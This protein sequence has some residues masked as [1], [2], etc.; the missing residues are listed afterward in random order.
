MTPLTGDE[1]LCP[2]RFPLTTLPGISLDQQILL[3]AVWHDDLCGMLAQGVVFS[4]EVRAVW[5]ELEQK[6]RCGGRLHRWA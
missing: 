2:D 1:Y 4:R 6:C 5:E 3:D